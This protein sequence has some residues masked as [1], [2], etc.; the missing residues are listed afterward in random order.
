MTGDALPT[1]EARARIAR[2]VAR[3]EGGTAGEIVVVLSARAG[4]YR[5]VVLL[6]GLVG[7]LALPWPLIALTP[8]SASAILVAQAGLVAAI[9]AAGLYEPLRVAL[10]PAR[11]RRAR[12]REAARLAFWSR[13]LS[14]T[15]GRTGVLLYLSMAERH[16]E[17][18]ADDGVLAR[19][20]PD[21]WSATLSELL[22]AL[23]A[24]EV[25][26]GLVRAVD[27]I[28][29]DLARHLPAGPD[30]PDELPNRVIVVD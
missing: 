13:G 26:G 16:A 3:A 20:G 12:T 5:S 1:P 14:R 11:I 29:A 19:I 30:D 18:V 4:Q 8:W 27:C 23:R 10:V 21:S 17:I 9:L 28:G 7:G 2:A 25:E 22:A 6:A 15:R 24:G